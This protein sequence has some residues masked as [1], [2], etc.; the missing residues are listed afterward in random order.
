MGFYRSSINLHLADQIQNMNKQY[1]NSM[2]QAP[3]VFDMN[4][5]GRALP[6]ELLHPEYRNVGFASYGANYDGKATIRDQGLV[7]MDPIT[8]IVG[9]S[10]LVGRYHKQ[11]DDSDSDSSSDCSSLNDE[12]IEKIEGGNIFGDIASAV[13]LGK[14]K[15][16]EEKEEGGNILGDIAG[17][18]GLGKEQEGGNILGDVT[19]YVKGIS[20]IGT[21]GTENFEG[22]L[23][24]PNFHMLVEHAPE[25]LEAMGKPK[26]E[27]EGGKLGLSSLVNNAVQFGSPM[28]MTNPVNVGMEILQGLGDQ[29]P[30]RKV[31]NQPVADKALMHGALGGFGKPKV[32]TKEAK[33]KL[34]LKV[35]GGNIKIQTNDK[36]DK[37]IEGG[38]RKPTEWQ[39]LV[40]KIMNDKKL[41]MGAA[42][43]HIKDN[44][45][46]TK[47]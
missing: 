5:S 18:F 11:G 21:T 8:N 19:N 22:L 14:D 35:E 2:D 32:H 36:K 26:K 24:N 40:K 25:L 9:G 6:N 4:L 13:G 12:D 42:I 45:L 43:K 41:K 3:N 16:R 38:K 27:K 31:Y 30:K 7:E 1:I 34:T 23:G 17:F 29:K 39:Q 28:T 47:K 33:E 20:G 44:N 10:K 15:E 46:Y 37:K